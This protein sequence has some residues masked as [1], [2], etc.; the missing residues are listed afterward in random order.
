M[1]KK[2]HT[3]EETVKLIEEGKLLVLSADEHLLAQL[4]KGYWIAGTIPYFMTENGGVFTKKMIFVDDISAFAT[5]SKIVNYNE[6]TISNITN[7]AFGNGFTVLILPA[8]TAVH[9]EFS[10]HSINYPDI[11]FKPIVGYVA[12]VEV[13][14]INF[15]K[16]KTFSGLTSAADNSNA[17]A[18]HVQLPENY[19]AKVEIF[20]LDRINPNSAHITV[21]KTSFVQSECVIDGETKNLAHYLSEINY[22]VGLPLIA[23]NGG[24]L[25]NRD[26]QSIDVEKGVVT[27]F[28]PVFEDETYRLA[29]PI[30]NYFEEFN[31]RLIIKNDELIHYSL[32]CVSYYLLGGLEGKKLPI[33]GAFTFGEIGYQILNQTIVYLTIKEYH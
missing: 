29:M 15:E 27:F 9:E 23:N 7:D 4:P 3:V 12:G 21:P 31:K 10:I 17:I 2:L 33:T 16:P 20:N 6:N 13:N 11:F 8:A 5:D 14:N 19:R 32:I 30:E 25:I 28:A 26:I 1:T 18:M 22:P 24:A